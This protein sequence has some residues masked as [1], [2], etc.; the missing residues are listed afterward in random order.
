[1]LEKLE[2]KF[3][4]LKLFDE[5]FGLTTAQILHN[6]SSQL[7]V[8]YGGGEIKVTRGDREYLM[9][10]YLPV[11]GGGQ[12]NLV[13]AP[14]FFEIKTKIPYT[15]PFFVIRKSNSLDWISEHVF[16]MPDYQIGDADFDA[17]FHIKVKDND[18]GSRF[19]SNSCIRLGVS[20]LLLQGFDLIRSEE[21]DLKVVKYLSLGGPHPTVE[22]INNAIEQVDIIISN[23]QN[24]YVATTSVSR[25]ETGTVSYPIDNKGNDLKKGNDEQINNKNKDHDAVIFKEVSR[26][27]GVLFF[28]VILCPII[29]IVLQ[30]NNIQIPNLRYVFWTVA[31]LGI[32]IF[33]GMGV[34]HI[35]FLSALSGVALE[36]YLYLQKR[37]FKT[38][39]ASSDNYLETVHKNG[40]SGAVVAFVFFLLCYIGFVRF[41]YFI[42]FDK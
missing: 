38:F 8:D 14:S 41:L 26:D 23:I 4:K 6:L 1:M 12:E 16:A 17:K 27:S 21:G 30:A 31:V 24:D 9:F 28:I 2:D 20:S 35:F 19:L 36:K 37:Y 7:G 29:L 42:T 39:T 25:N 11:R 18:W 22:M 13:G 15:H 5:D 34:V 40:R 33:L 32:L 10:I 3:E